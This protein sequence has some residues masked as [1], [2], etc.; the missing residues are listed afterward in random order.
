MRK[1]TA[2]IFTFGVAMEKYNYN[3]KSK[4][5]LPR[6]IEVYQPIKF[7]SK[8]QLT[9]LLKNAKVRNSSKLYTFFSLLAFTG[10]RKSETLSLQWREVDYFNTTINIGK[11]IALL[12]LYNHIFVETSNGADD[13][14]WL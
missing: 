3:P 6:K 5:L 4:T 8:D 7:Y 14:S 1:T 2:Q 12:H 10:T 9:V 13:Y 11:K